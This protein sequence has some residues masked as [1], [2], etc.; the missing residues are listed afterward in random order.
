MPLLLGSAVA[1]GAVPPQLSSLYTTRWHVQPFD[2]FN[3]QINGTFAQRYLVYD[4]FGGNPNADGPILFYTGAEGTGVDAIFPH[5]GPILDLGRKLG[6]LLLVF[7]EMRF[8]GKSMPFGEIDSF[9]KDA[10]HLGLLT[11]EQTLADYASLIVSL[12]SEYNA[13]ASPVIAIGGSLAGSLTYFLRYK[14]PSI[15]DMG[16]AAS[17]PIL[18]Y[19]GLTSQYGWYRVATETLETQAP[20]CP[21][22]VRSRFADMIAATAPTLTTAFNACTPIAA[23]DTQRVVGE[24]VARLTTSLASAA[25]SAYPKRSSPVVRACR[26]I[27]AGMGAASFRPLIVP[28]G[29]CLD[30]TRLLGSTDLLSRLPSSPNLHDDLRELHDNSGDARGAS[31]AGKAWYY[32]ACTEIVHPIGANNVSDCFPPQPW[33]LAGLSS[34]CNSLFNVRPRPAWLPMA[35]G[36]AGG[37]ERIAASTSHVIFSNGLLDPWSSQS[38]LHNLSPSLIVLNITDGSHHSDIGAPP[39]PTPAA[40]DSESVV[41][42]RQ[43]EVEILSIWVTEARERRRMAAMLAPRDVQQVQYQ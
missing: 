16:L 39:N 41:A 17:A 36:M 1:S 37:P 15:V 10:T 38:V 33:S 22:A 12:R 3:A 43:R 19:P 28:P 30:I 34:T 26:T 11:I 20:G 6:S 2:H 18:G 35:M 25:E 13:E 8:F 7:A 21:E 14:Y 32:L 29:Q 31:T 42:A 40:S 23:A 24:L 9:K 4:S 27:L 5:S